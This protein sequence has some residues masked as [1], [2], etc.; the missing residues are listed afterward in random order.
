M[1][2]VRHHCPIHQHQRGVLKFSI[3]RPD[4][5]PRDPCRSHEL[6]RHTARAVWACWWAQRA[7]LTCHQQSATSNPIQLLPAPAPTGLPSQRTGCRGSLVCFS[8]G[9][10]CVNFPPAR[11]FPAPSPPFFPPV[12]PRDRDYNTRGTPTAWSLSRSINHSV[13]RSIASVSRNIRPGDPSCPIM[14]YSQYSGNPYQSGPAQE[15]AYGA[16][17]PYGAPVC[18]PPV[19]DT[20]PCH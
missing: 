19:A 1:G 16:P 7:T 2:W 3:P 15:S 13:Y 5:A 14:S 18:P 20:M 11:P 4:P 8:Q 10:R 6:K 17:N 12:A 9:G